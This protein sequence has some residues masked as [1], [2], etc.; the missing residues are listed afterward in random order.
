M[1]KVGRSSTV[2]WAGEGVAVEVS[3]GLLVNGLHGWM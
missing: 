2:V 1:L 3:H